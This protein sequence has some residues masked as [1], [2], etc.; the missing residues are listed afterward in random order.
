VLEPNLPRYL[1]GT[2]VRVIPEPEF[3][4]ELVL[5]GQDAAGKPLT[6]WTLTVTNATPQISALFRATS[7]PSYEVSEVRI[8]NG[9][10]TLMVRG[11]AGTMVTVQATE[12]FATWTDV[13]TI[14]IGTS[15]VNV[16]AVGTIPAG[17]THRFYR[18]KQGP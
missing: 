12:D 8:E 6:E 15:G 18:I 9:E 11:S 3:G 7:P 10:L 14:T 13:K 16:E 17:E 5:W 2:Q 4:N 1:Y